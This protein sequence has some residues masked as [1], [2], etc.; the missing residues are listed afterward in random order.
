MSFKGLTTLGDVPFRDHDSL[1]RFKESSLTDDIRRIPSPMSRPHGKQLR[2][3]DERGP[4]TARGVRSRI[5]LLRPAVA[6][7]VSALRCP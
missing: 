5:L 2:R 3:L 7:H 1:L 4:L 6:R